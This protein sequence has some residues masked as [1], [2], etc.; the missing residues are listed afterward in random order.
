[1]VSNLNKSLCSSRSTCPPYLFLLHPCRGCPAPGGERPHFRSHFRSSGQLSL[2]PLLGVS[3]LLASH[4]LHRCASGQVVGGVRRRGDWDPC[5]AGWQGEGK[6]SVQ[7]SRL[8]QLHLLPWWSVTV[9]GRF[10][11]Q[12]LGPLSLQSAA[13]PGGRQCPH[14]TYGQR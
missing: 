5:V 4:L 12:R 13:G 7:R 14:T 8:A 11:L 9:A 10:A 6:R 1:M 3:V 2:N